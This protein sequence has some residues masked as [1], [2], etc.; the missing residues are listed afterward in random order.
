MTKDNQKPELKNAIELAA[1]GTSFI[2]SINPATAV[3]GAITGVG[4]FAWQGEQRQKFL[5]ALQ[6]KL[7]A[8]DQNKL[9]HSALESDEFKSLAIQAVETASK[10]ASDSKRQALASALTSSIVL[11]L[12]CHFPE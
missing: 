3:I 6:E 11:T 5:D 12:F 2:L 8:L 1:A 7:D 4:L 10:T 9:D